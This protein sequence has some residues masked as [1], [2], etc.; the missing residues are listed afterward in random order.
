MNGKREYDLRDQERREQAAN[1]RVGAL[2]RVEKFD[3]ASMRVDVQPLSKALD[4]GVYRTQPQILSVPVALVR[5][6]GFVLRPCYKAGDVGVLLYIDHDIDRI[7]A[8]GEESEPNT[9]RNHSDEDAVFIGAF[10]PASNPL[11]GL[12]DNCLVM[13]TE[14]GGIYVAVK[15]DKVEIKGDVE[16]Q[17]KVKVRDD[18]IAKTI[19]LVNHKHTDSRN[20]NTS[21]PLP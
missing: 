5:G 3:P 21:A 19:S 20:G 16:V 13:A 1:V 8:S 9:E 18:V 15:Q 12:P 17:G 2:C 10:V 7:A 6:G 4:A 11:S 14:G